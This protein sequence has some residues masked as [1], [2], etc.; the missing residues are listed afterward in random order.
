[1]IYKDFST[2]DKKTRSKLI[3]GS[4]SPR[5]IAWIS[6][7]NDNATVNLAPFSF[8]TMLSANYVG[9]SIQKLADSNK[10]TYHNI[11]TNKEAVINIASLEEL[12]Q[13]DTSSKPLA[14]NIS[15]VELQQL[16]LV[17]SNIVKTPGLKMCK[18]RLEVIL[19]KT[20]P[21][22]GEDKKVEADLVILKVVAGHFSEEVLNKDTNYIDIET[23]NPVSRLA[24]P[25]YATTKLIKDFKRQY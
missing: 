6:S 25:N 4:V 21:L 9:V 5:P 3:Q 24:G 20:I 22:L 14:R 7:L 12:E 17:K 19:E 16:E 8:F 18:I 11:I 10:D 23:L 13:L 15:E 2:L 1:M